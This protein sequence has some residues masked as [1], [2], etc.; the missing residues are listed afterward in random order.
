MDCRS[1][2]QSN[3]ARLVAER[4]S[5]RL[6]GGKS[7]LWLLSGGS[8][9]QVCVDASKL[10]A[11]KDLSRLYVTFSDERYGELGHPD[12]NY[13]I[14]IEKGLFLPGAT[15]YRPLAGM[16]K[17]ETANSLSKWLR[18]ACSKVE[19]RFAVMGIGE[20]GHTA[21]AKPDS[22][23]IGSEQEAVIFQAD[24]FTR[25]TVTLKFIKSLD[26][27][28]VQAYGSSKHSIVKKFLNKDGTIDDFPALVIHDIPRVTLFTD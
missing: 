16:S 11:D 21:G 19:Y 10:L 18:D 20:D 14:L 24:D 3:V 23:A 26:E 13:Q 5:D 9:G 15:I 17:A 2:P 28:V 6:K 8:G 22:P 25:L 7:V 4:I 12:E 27:A 1:E